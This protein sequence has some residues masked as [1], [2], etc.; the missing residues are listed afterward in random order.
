MFCR[1]KNVPGHTRPQNFGQKI[2]K[3]TIFK[4]NP[5]L[6]KIV[7]VQ[8]SYLL[9][10]IIIG[11]RGSEILREKRILKTLVAFGQFFSPIF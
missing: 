2:R 5:R 8:K 10:I 3:I 4:T 1:G 9:T 11:F 7:I 6:I